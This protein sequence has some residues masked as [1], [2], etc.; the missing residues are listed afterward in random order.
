[1]FKNFKTRINEFGAE[2]EKSYANEGSLRSSS[3]A[4]LPS[5]L[6]RFSPVLSRP[7]SPQGQEALPESLEAENAKLRSELAKVQDQARRRMQEL[8]EQEQQNQQ[9]KVAIIASL[10]TQLQEKEEKLRVQDT[11][12]QILQ[13]DLQRRPGKDKTPTNDTPNEKNGHLVDWTED[14]QQEGPLF[15]G[16]PIDSTSIHSED[17]VSLKKI[18]RCCEEK[19]SI[20]AAQKSQVKDMVLLHEKEKAAIQEEGKVIATRVEELKAINESLQE[21]LPKIAEANARADEAIAD[22]HRM[23]RELAEMKAECEQASINLSLLTNMTSEV[24]NMKTL[25]DELK[26][27]ITKLE[28]S[29]A[30]AARKYEISLKKQ[31]ARVEKAR[32]ELDKEMVSAAEEIGELNKEVESLRAQVSAATSAPPASAL[33][34]HDAQT[35]A[36]TSTTPPEAVSDREAPEKVSSVAQL[37]G[38]IEDRSKLVADL[39]AREEEIAGLREQ[40][41]VREEKCRIELEQYNTDKEKANQNMVD[42]QQ[43]LEEARVTVNRL[44]TERDKLQEEVVAATSTANE[45]NIAMEE[46]RAQL[47][48]LMQTQLSHEEESQAWLK[49]RADLVDQVRALN[50]KMDSQAIQEKESG[51]NEREMQELQASLTTLTNQKLVWESEQKELLLQYTTVTDTVRARDLALETAHTQLA[52]AQGQ[53]QES[54]AELKMVQEEKGELEGKCERA[55]QEQASLQDQVRI[56]GDQRRELQG[57]LEQTLNEQTTLQANLDNI[58]LQYNASLADL[59]AAQTNVED[60]NR[61]WVKERSRYEDELSALH[62]QVNHLTSTTDPTAPSPTTPVTDKMSETIALAI[63]EEVPILQSV[64]HTK[65]KSKKRKGKGGKAHSGDIPTEPTPSEVITKNDTVLDGQGED[66]EPAST[67]PLNDATAQLRSV[68]QKLLE[69]EAL[70]QT[71]EESNKNMQCKIENLTKD[72]EIAHLASQQASGDMQD[73]ETT[74][75]QLDLTKTKV[76]ELEIRLQQATNECQAKTEQLAVVEANLLTL[77]SDLITSQTQGRTSVQELE[78][79]LSHSKQ[80]QEREDALTI[81]VTA[82]EAQLEQMRGKY[83]MAQSEVVAKQNDLATLSDTLAQTKAQLASGRDLEAE[84]VAVAKELEEERATMAALRARLEEAEKEVKTLQMTAVVNNNEKLALEEQ[85]TALQQAVDLQVQTLQDTVHTLDEKLAMALSEVETLQNA[86]AQSGKELTAEKDCSNAL[87]E[88]AG[89]WE[90]KCEE[91]QQTC[92]H[93]RTTLTQAEQDIE[94]YSKEAKA[95]SDGLVALEKKLS[96]A[97]ASNE[98]LQSLQV[99]NDEV[100]ANYMASLKTISILESE[101]TSL[102]EKVNSF[103]TIIQDITESKKELCSELVNAKAEGQTLTEKLTTLGRTM[104]DTKRRAEKAE[105]RAHNRDDAT[106]KERTVSQ[107]LRI[108]IE[109]HLATVAGLHTD[110]EK[111]GKEMQ[112][113]KV[114]MGQLERQ[115]ADAKLQATEE[116]KRADIAQELLQKKDKALEELRG[117]LTTSRESIM[118]LT[119]KAEAGHLAAQQLIVAN[120]LVDELQLRV[121]HWRTLMQGGEKVVE[122]GIRIGRYGLVDRLQQQT[123]LQMQTQLKGAAERQE[124]INKIK[125]AQDDIAG[126]NTRLETEKQERTHEV[127]KIQTKHQQALLTQA[128]QAKTELEARVKEIQEEMKME[129]E[130]LQQKLRQ[131]ISNMA[132]ELDE[133]KA[134]L[135]GVDDKTHQA[136]RS[137]VDELRHMH[138]REVGKL[139]KHIRELEYQGQKGRLEDGQFEYLR[140][141]TLKYMLGTQ[142]K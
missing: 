76:Q 57:R 142:K 25:N 16:K 71:Q 119:K 126:L 78:T 87:M 19:D 109:K 91:V 102:G 96:E 47:A 54:L 97:Q 23:E 67:A 29:Q 73:L 89:Q 88:E 3:A 90:R 117:D 45:H 43:Q 28:E 83:D 53:L 56:I 134:E 129:A 4:S 79:A 51:V 32:A 104:S 72:L 84:A 52:S 58:Q 14:D 44:E 105:A 112:G 77:Q 138:R 65:K 132:T 64:N 111:V 137:K 49:E 35:E 81:E 2:V 95:Q 61:E 31:K 135:I 68:E 140:N 66:T 18:Q 11:Q 113:L 128:H 27:K 26:S 38:N 13:A 80:L 55:Q 40:F 20:I 141:I 21:Q 101:L 39:K 46:V 99:K 6:G 59:E 37:I 110:L 85:V 24:D 48:T 93:L 103:K 120:E 30:T 36:V 127:A 63:K 42:L 10:E 100:E 131:D 106:A 92:D 121:S 123:Q 70:L 17:T 12:L 115:V 74:L 62:T 50:E 108:E 118:D 86:L 15:T 22:K 34:S 124:L 107:S 114:A 8:K 122:R 94:R 9:A 33:E 5:S 69:T 139:E 41:R 133:A 125:T 7:S 60:S 130:A 136:V 98:I 75:S 82:L 1:M 116:T